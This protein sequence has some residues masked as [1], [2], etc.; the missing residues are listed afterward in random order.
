MIKI[1]VYEIED[2]GE[3]GLSLS[4]FDYVVQKDTHLRAINETIPQNATYTSL[5]EQNKIIAALSTV[6]TEGIKD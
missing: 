3:N 4:L 5:D 6:A 2:N 1:E